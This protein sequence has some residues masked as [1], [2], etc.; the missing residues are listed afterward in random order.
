MTTASQASK[1]ITPGSTE[2]GDRQTLQQGLSAVLGGGGGAPAGG[3][4]PGPGGP[5]PLPDTSDPLGALLSGAVKPGGGGPLTDGLSVG[6]GV[7][8]TNNDPMMG[9]SAQ[10]LRALAQEAS[11]PFLRQAALGLLRDM[12]KKAL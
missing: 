10:R 7:G 8:P 12:A 9:D 2:Y 5:P 1:A 6:P 11:T 4:V 3:P